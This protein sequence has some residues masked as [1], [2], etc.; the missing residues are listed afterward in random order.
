[1]VVPLYGRIT[2]TEKSTGKKEAK[3]GPM[4]INFDDN[5]FKKLS[6]LSTLCANPLIFVKGKRKLTRRQMKSL[7]KQD[8]TFLSKCEA[9]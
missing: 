4:Y 2:W 7:R 8:E 3:L 5:C 1:M 6:E 9:N